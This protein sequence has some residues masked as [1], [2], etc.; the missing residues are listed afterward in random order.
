MMQSSTLKVAVVKHVKLPERSGRNAGF[1]F[2]VHKNFD[3]VKLLPLSSVNVPSGIKVRVPEGHALIAFNKSG[4]AI[5]GLQVGAC[6]IDENYTG[7]IHLHVTNIGNKP[8]WIKRHMKLVQF[9]L[10]PVTY[11]DVEHVSHPDKLYE[12]F[13]VNERGENGFGST[14]V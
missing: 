4:M 1:D 3:N 10:I 2:F 6:V 11:A 7:E 5:K 9:L 12:D 8:I 13:D 14:G